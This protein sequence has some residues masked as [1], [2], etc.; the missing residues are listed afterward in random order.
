M[1][2]TVDWISLILAGGQLTLVVLAARLAF[3][4]GKLSQQVEGILK[5]AIEEKKIIDHLMYEGDELRERIRAT[6]V[7]VEALITD[8][9]RMRDESRS[10]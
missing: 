2:V 9:T 4:F 5:A 7:R 1:E 3:S 10:N 6:E 8:L